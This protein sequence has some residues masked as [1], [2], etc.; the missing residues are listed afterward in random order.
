MNKIKEW[1]NDG[2]F[3]S[4]GWMLAIWSFA[5]S[6]VTIVDMTTFIAVL[7]FIALV[8]FAMHF[9]GADGWI[10]LIVISIIAAI[11]YFIL[12]LLGPKPLQALVIVG[13]W[14]YFLTFI[15]Y[16]ANL[17]DHK[18]EGDNK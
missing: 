9:G 13:G 10:F 14:L 16:V 18:K 1:R 12:Y 17:S 3:L 11:I 2:D 8:L 15:C 6:M 7:E 4:W 5:F